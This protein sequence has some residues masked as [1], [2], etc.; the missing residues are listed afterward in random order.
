MAPGAKRSWGW[1]VSSPSAPQAVRMERPRLGEDGWSRGLESACFWLLAG[2]RV[3]HR[4]RLRVRCTH[5]RSASAPAQSAIT[6]IAEPPL[7][8]EDGLSAPASVSKP[9]SSGLQRSTPL[10]QPAFQYEP[11][12]KFGEGL[13]TRRPWNTDALAGV[14]R[15]NGRVA[16]LGFAAALIGEWLTGHGP[17]G[18][19]LAVLRWYLS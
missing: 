10:P 12:E 11:V 15:L 14:E 9:I 1:A 6:R 7:R 18:Q 13:T 3:V 5:H 2:W 19:L 17:A 8:D 16:M 4:G